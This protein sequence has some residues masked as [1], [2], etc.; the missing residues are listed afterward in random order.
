MKCALVWFRRDL[1]VHD[2][3]PLLSAS[4]SG[5]PVVGLYCLDPREYGVTGF[6]YPKTGA[7]RARFILE[8]VAELRDNLNKLGIPLLVRLGKPEEVIPEL[9]QSGLDL[10]EVHAHDELGT[11]ESYVQQQVK[12]SLG[13]AE[14]YTY[15]GHSLVHPED[16]PFPLEELPKL[17]TPFKQ[18]ILKSQERCI[19]SMLPLPE[20]QSVSLAVEE[21]DLPELAALGLADDELPPQPVFTGGSSA[22]RK[23]LT[24]YFHEQDN[25]SR[26]SETRNGM[27]EPDASSKLSPYL[28]LGCL[29]PRFVYWS[30]KEAEAARSVNESTQ[31]FL[32]ELLW[33]E[34]FIYVHRKHGSRIFAAGGLDGKRLEWSSDPALLQAWTE[35]ETGYPLVDANMRELRQTG[36]MSN[37]GRQNTASFLAKNLGIDWRAGAQWFESQL[38]DYDVSVNYGNWCYNAAV[39]NDTRPYRIFNVSKQ[40]RDYDPAGDYAKHWLPELAAVPGEQVYDVPEWTWFEQQEFGLEL[41]KDYPFPIVEWM[42]SVEAF[43]SRLKQAKG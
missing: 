35:G 6:G 4:A 40:G 36:W 25:I 7:H 30:L 9:N 27:L 18:R 34:Y 38:L 29:S 31:G 39:G 12:D 11:E 28:A 13:E 32:D 23:R 19:R 14:L 2:N 3:Q 20:R 26:Y 41:G 22:G 16:L 24:Y 1:R 8:S 43:R 42:P 10:V 33:R 17:Y 5:L 37:R 21:G 15:F